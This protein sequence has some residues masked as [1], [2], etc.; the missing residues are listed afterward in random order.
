MTYERLLQKVVVNLFDVPKFQKS[1]FSKDFL[2]LNPTLLLH[3]LLPMR[4]NCLACLVACH[5]IEF[6]RMKT[7]EVQVWTWVCWVRSVDQVQSGRSMRTVQ[8]TESERS[9]NKLDGPNGITVNFYPWEM[10][11]ERPLWLE[12]KSTIAVHFGPKG[13][14]VSLKTVSFRATF[15]FK[16]RPVSLD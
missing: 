5:S 2:L 6:S 11:H 12:T 9:Y 14:T 16:D 13:R 4:R 3:L 8:A 1:Q 7:D 10:G 15:D